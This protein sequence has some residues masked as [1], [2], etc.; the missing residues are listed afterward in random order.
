[1]PFKSNYMT[2]TLHRVDDV[3]GKERVIGAGY[4]VTPGLLRAMGAKFLAGDSAWRGDSGT[5]VITREMLTELLPGTTPEVSI[6]QSVRGGRDA[7]YRIAGVVADMK[8]SDLTEAA[9]PTVFRPL[10]DGFVGQPFTMVVRTTAASESPAQTIGS[11]MSVAAPDVPPYDVRSVRDAVDQQFAERRVMAIVASM[12]G[13]LG[14]VLATVGLYGVLANVVSSEQ[15][16]IAIRAALGATPAEILTRVL[17]RG[18][19][20][21]VVGAAAGVV[22]AAAMNR[23]LAS[24]LFGLS[25]LDPGAFGWA[26]GTMSTLA[27]V[28][29]LPPAYRATRVSIVQMLRAE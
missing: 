12:L 9:P 8:L 28:A 25:A 22:G 15:R 1:M 13:V 18:F 29:C 5:V 20:P 27:L 2:A 17:V 11:A 4:Y 14:V 3:E 6:G 24:Q 23:L 26:I 21:V 7:V 19:V 16:A 10:R